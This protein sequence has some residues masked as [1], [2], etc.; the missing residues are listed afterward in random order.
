M[1]ST[2]TLSSSSSGSI[3][4]G[5]SSTMASIPSYQILNHTLPVKLDRTNYIL[6]RSQIDNVIFANGFEDFIDGTSICPER[7][8]SPGV[9]NPAFVAWRRQD[10]TI[11]SWIY[12]SLTPGIMAQIIGHNTSHS[13]WNALESIF[14]SSSRARIM[15]LR[16]ELQSTKKGSMSMI[17][18][19]MKIKRAADNL[20]A[21]GEPVS[22]QDQVMNLLGGLGSDYNVVVTAINIRDDKISLEAIH[23]MLLAFEHRLEQQSSIE[24][25]SANYASSSNNRGAGRKFNGGRGQGYAPNNNNYTYRG[26][27]RGGR[28]GH[29]GRQNSSPSEKPQCQLCGKFG[30]TAQICYHRFD[31]SFQGGQSS[32]SP[33]LNNGNQNNIPAMVASSSNSPVD[34][35]WY[36]A[37]GA[38]HHLTQNLG[39]LTSTS[40]YTRTDRVTIGNAESSTPAIIAPTPSLIP[41]SHISHTS[42]DSHS[43]STSASSHPTDSSPLDTSS[44]SPTIDLPPES[45]PAPQVPAP[46]MTTRFMHG[47]TKKK[48]ILDLSAIKVSEPS[49]LKQAFK[50]PNWTKAIEMEIAALHRN[51][52]WDLVEKPPDVNVIGC[53]WVYKL[54]HKPDGSIERYKARLVAK[55]YNQT[56]S[57]D[58]FETFSSVV[59]AATIRIILTVALSFKWEIR[60]LDVHNAFLNGELDE[61]VYMSQPPGYL[62]SQFPNRV[63]RLKKAL[64]GL[65]QAPRAWFQRLSSALLQ[66]GFNMSRTD[67]SMFLHFGQA[68][69]LIILAYVD[70][71]IITGSSSTQISSLI[72]KLDSIFALR[73]LGPLSFFLGIEVSYNEGYMNLSQTKYIFDLLHITEMFDTKPA[74][75]PGSVGKN[76]SKFDGDPLANATYYRSVVGALQYVTLTR[77]DIAF[78]INKACQFMQQPSTAHWI[79]IKRILRYLRGTMQDGL[80]L[81]PSS[82]LTIEG[83]TDADWGAH[84]DDRHSSSGYLSEYRG[85]VFATAEIVWMQALLQEL[86]VPLS[87]IPLLW[88]DNISAYHMAKNPVFHARTKHI[89]IDLHF[90][91][92]QV[93]RGKI[94]LHFVPTEEQPADLLTKHLTSSRFLSLK[95]QLCIAPRPV[96]LRGDDKQRS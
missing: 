21:I 94:Q 38:S 36:L 67:S 76:L 44:S 50:D 88:Y 53:K 52:T 35:N 48:T 82:N 45:V 72:A 40:P 78:A 90:I 5:Q 79:S 46:R 15:Q 7:N 2:P 3:G 32:T 17:D 10:R 1:A 6:W 64:Y 26:R 34:E 28:N 37:S 73:D 25:I 54:K 74:K 49:T 55:G 95:S 80:L 23:R 71:I 83:F 91:R 4:S 16:F 33:S 63:C 30:H 93:M 19:I 12:S 8:L 39:N 11:L 57:L 31:I 20:V 61:Q 47:I 85:L 69:T 62:D 86:C 60:Q 14:S 43:L 70:D 77:P 51:H 96:H 9:I 18:Y 84:L 22:E 89:E 81:S 92:D 58:Y 27:G 29:G 75:T 41:Y 66:W 13:A 87:E 65:K 24:Q 68:T 56:H 42:I 59:K